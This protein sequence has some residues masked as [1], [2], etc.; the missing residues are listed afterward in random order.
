[1][2]PARI[3]HSSLQ[4]IEIAPSSSS[5]NAPNSD[6]FGYVSLAW[7][8]KYTVVAIVAACALLAFAYSLPQPYIFKAQTTLEIQE[9]NES[10]LNFKDLE[11]TTRNVTMESFVQTQVR[12]LQS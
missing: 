8:H 12:I 4:P 5:Y 6:L 11:T 1:M 9:P 10:F 2:L 7:T 3:D